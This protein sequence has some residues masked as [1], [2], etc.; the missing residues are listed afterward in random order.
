MNNFMVKIHFFPLLH[1]FPYSFFL[2]SFLFIQYF[3]LSFFHSSVSLYS[4]FFLPF[5]PFLLFSHLPLHLPSSIPFIFSFTSLTHSVYLVSKEMA[6]GNW[7][8]NQAVIRNDS[9]SLEAAPVV[10]NHAVQGLLVML[11][12][13]SRLLW[14]LDSFP[15]FLLPSWRR[16]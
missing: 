14:L 5:F 11:F 13:Y 9:R 4:G 3:I 10:N 12:Y 16:A 8:R 7:D 2:I 15:V 1:P 6:I